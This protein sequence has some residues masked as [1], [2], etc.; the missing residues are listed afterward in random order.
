MPDLDD[1]LAVIA[2]SLQRHAMVTET[3]AQI[4]VRLE[5][6]RRVDRRL[7]LFA[8]TLTGCGLL[9]TGLVA[10]GTGWLVWFHLLH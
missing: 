1:P 6:G 2:Q 8:L 3:L 9:V 5:D 4:L 7:H 10:L